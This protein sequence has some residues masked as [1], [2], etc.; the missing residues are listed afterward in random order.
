MA[1]I[2]SRKHAVG[3][4]PSPQL[5]GAA[6]A[7][8]IAISMPVAAQT[9]T[10]N[11]LREVKIEATA[12]GYKPET[13]SSPKFTQ[14]LVDTPQTITVIKKEVLQDQGATTLTEA[15]RNT[16]GIT[17][18]M[19]ENGNTSTGD[20]VFMRGFD[21][22]GS[23]FV[24]GI[25]DVGTVSRDMFNIE[26]VEVVKGPAGADIGR[27]SPTGYINLVSKVPT[28]E[29]FFAGS[30][31]LGS[32][33]Q[34]RATV[35]LNRALN[36][37][38]SVA[39][40]LNAM[41]Q[42]GGVPGRDLVENNRSGI[43]PSLAIGLGTPTRIYLSYLHMDQKNRPDGGIPVVG[44]EGYYLA[45]LARIGGNG[46]R[47]DTNNYYGFLSDHD[48]VKADMFTAR[49]EHDIAPG[50]TIRNISR[51]GR[52]KQD[53]VL[54]GVF[55]N[56]LLVPNV[57]NP[58][59]WS[60][61]TTPQGKL[62]DNEI[63]ANQTNI[64]ADLTLGGLKH[65]ISAG[66]EL[67]REEQDN[68]AVAA[69]INALNGVR[70]GTSFLAYNNLYAP[71][72]N[73]AF[74]PVLPTGASTAGKTTT[75]ALYAFDTIKLNEQWLI[76]GG[77]RYEHYKSDFSGLDAPAAN[78]TQLATRLGKSDNLLTG[79]VGVVFKPAPNG[80]IYAAYATSAK[81][82]GSDFA[83][84]GTATNI[85]NPN[86][87]P[88]KAKTAEVGTK[89]DLLDKRLA[90]TGAL[91]RT[92]NENEQVQIDTFGNTEQYGKTRVQGVELSAIG[93][94]T[95]AWQVIAGIASIDT[96]I[97]EGS[98]TSTTQNG[99][100]IRFS[101][102]LTATLWTTYKFP[103]G[104]IVGAGA[105]YVDTQARATSNAALTPTTFFPTI[106]SYTVF[107]AMIGYEINKNVAIQLNL[108]NLTD[109]FYL[110]RVNNAG[111][112]LTVGTPRSATLT[113][114]FKF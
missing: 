4:A 64:T 113:A 95:P 94:I 70:S 99:A 58:L 45:D 82:P 2:K 30:V 102:K 28:A 92:T 103:M 31:S 100:Q 101:P 72:V 67:G 37:T 83:L 112:R 35:D 40:R 114:N 56:G 65:S 107:D 7:T 10:A 78:G 49:I 68:T 75:A 54:T 79:K 93:Q 61:R 5:T 76:N 16:P 41:V 74:V 43:A 36:E 23:I 87:D 98:R 106:P 63:F 22:S 96:E 3:R 104:L 86:L 55:S 90:V 33:S 25:R 80:S 39:F 29:N 52:T 18:Q 12:D 44:L 15:L 51:W 21:T 20:A 66:V 11:T 91:F 53:L 97:L 6:A 9:N 50:V 59:G 1:Y 42:D 84:S 19:G 48:D 85:N 111:N 46:P 69:Q 62:Q 27:G 17:F 89:W 26:Q 14:P 24:D 57:F 32:A 88:Q 73:R 81:P 110:A 34:K 71:N 77:L 8:L 38:G 105:R 47:V 108:Y 13:S 109:K 60:V